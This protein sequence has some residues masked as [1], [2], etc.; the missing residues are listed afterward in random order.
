M[1]REYTPADLRA[2]RARYRL[3][4]SDVAHMFNA[5]VTTL[6]RWE[7]EIGVPPDFHDRMTKFMK[8]THR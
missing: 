6:S 8:R 3:K 1:T 7:R 5:S 2:I 4:L